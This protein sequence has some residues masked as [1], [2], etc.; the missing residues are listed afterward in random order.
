MINNDSGDKLMKIK[1]ME[2]ATASLKEIVSIRNAVTD[3]GIR[4]TRICDDL[5]QDDYYEM[6]RH[7]TD[8]KCGLLREETLRK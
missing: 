4:L 3:I 5:N 6:L 1:Q 7:L 8:I 2:S